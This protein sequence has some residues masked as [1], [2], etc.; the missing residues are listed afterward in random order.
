MP[1]TPQAERLLCACVTSFKTFGF[2]QGISS[3][4][5]G[6]SSSGSSNQLL[7]YEDYLKKARGNLPMP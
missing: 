4:L 1:K 3:Q 7:L 2:F 5:F 6:V